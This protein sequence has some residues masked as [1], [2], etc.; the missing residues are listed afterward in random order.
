MT[1]RP[2]TWSHARADGRDDIGLGGIV[3]LV[4]LVAAGL[5]HPLHVPHHLC[6]L[7]HQRPLPVIALAVVHLRVVHVSSLQ[8][9]FHEARQWMLLMV[10]TVTP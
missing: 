9:C 2:E 7:S 1:R 5:R 3:I 8:M 10:M 6:Q 4:K